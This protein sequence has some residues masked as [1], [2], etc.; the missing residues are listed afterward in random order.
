MQVCKCQLP[1][2][3]P[4]QLCLCLRPSSTEVAETE[5]ASFFLLFL[6]LRIHFGTI[7][8]QAMNVHSL[9]WSC[10]I[11]KL[12]TS[13]WK[14]ALGARYLSFCHQYIASHWCACHLSSSFHKPHLTFGFYRLPPVWEMKSKR[15]FLTVTNPLRWLYFLG[16]IWQVDKP[17]AR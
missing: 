15:K 7:S 2:A 5:T 14:V 11:P 16:S 12:E 9:S 10:F 1:T 3:A 4:R 13:N 8:E 17:D 6:L